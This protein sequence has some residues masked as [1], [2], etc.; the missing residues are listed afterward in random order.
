MTNDG[1]WMICPLC[2]F[3]FETSTDLAMHVDTHLQEPHREPP[4][5][6]QAITKELLI[7]NDGK[8]NS[9]TTK[10]GSHLSQQSD[11]VN[12]TVIKSHKGSPSILA[13]V[14][15]DFLPNSI[16]PSRLANLGSHPKRQRLLSINQNSL[17]ISPICAA[18]LANA[19]SSCQEFIPVL[20]RCFAERIAQNDTRR[21]YLCHPAIRFSGNL[22]RDNWSCG[23]R[24]LQMMLS[25]VCTMPEFRQM[26]ESFRLGTPDIKKIQEILHSAWQQGFDVEGAA[27]L[28]NHIKGTRKWIGTTECATVLYYM[29]INAKIYDVHKPSGPNNSHP[30]LVDFLL[31]Y[32]EKDASDISIV[33]QRYI[34]PIY[35]QHQGHSRTVVGI[36]VSNDGNINLIVFDP[37][38][39]LPRNLE[40]L[41]QPRGTSVG[42][43]TSE[44]TNTTNARDLDRFIAHFRLPIAHL[45]RHTQYS[46]L[47]VFQDN[48]VLSAQQREQSKQLV[49]MRIV[50]N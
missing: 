35:L 3:P 45:S 42:T 25:I 50:N 20:A 48:A 27:Q 5:D 13:N 49:S 46:L 6:E 33:Q 8:K 47:C 14:M 31:R 9:S 30:A 2:E 21:V 37:G 34:L 32:F 43:S 29:N 15:P 22:K 18:G 28:G 26:H 17:G 12:P 23:Y 39:M 44:P 38:R 1:R 36:E 41:I 19:S 16:E 4:G 10:T 40:Y 11:G 24:N 7:S